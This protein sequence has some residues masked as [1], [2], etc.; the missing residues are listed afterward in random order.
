MSELQNDSVESEVIESTEVEKPDV[1][2]ELATASES[3]HSENT[4]KVEEVD[5]LAKKQAYINTQ[6]GE[7]KQLERDL[8][9]AKEQNY[10]FEQ[11]ER[12]RQ[13]AQVET[14]PEFPDEFDDNFEEK[15][16]K[17]IEAVR[18]QEAFNVQQ[19]LYTQQQQLQ[20]E[21]EAQAK[22][23]QQA[24][25]EQDFLARAKG[26]GAKDD[27]IISVISTLVT[28]GVGGD[29]GNAVMSNPDGYFI[30]KHLAAN[31]ME[32]HELTT[33]NPILA[34]TKF[35]EMA[36]KASALKPKTSNAPEPATN[37]SGNGVD[38]D[39]NQYKYIAGSEI[40]MGSAWN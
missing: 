7:K 26:T 21:R 20:Q 40:D 13:A 28:A 22:Q 17:Y 4:G 37:L 38:P 36:A 34:G 6:Y 16:D 27:E 2:A 12:E 14:L 11:A 35:A 5:E 32:V 29:L 31:P 1:G 18:K 39:S 3:E 19:S 25:L 33:M 24:K 10:K 15:K 9:A 23:Q 30:A 8:A